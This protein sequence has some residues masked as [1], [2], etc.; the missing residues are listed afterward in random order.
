M[1]MSMI[2]SNHVDDASLRN[3]RGQEEP[4]KETSTSTST[5]F[6]VMAVPIML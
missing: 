2:S 4:G 1:L 3:V 6:D 5:S